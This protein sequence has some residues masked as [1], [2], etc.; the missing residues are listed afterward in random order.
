[1]A[2]IG[3]LLFNEVKET[4]CKEIENRLTQCGHRLVKSQSFIVSGF[5]SVAH[6]NVAV[7]TGWLR[8]EAYSPL[9]TSSAL[10]SRP[11]KAGNAAWKH[12]FANSPDVYARTESLARIAR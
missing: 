9:A 7:L 12:A 10:L 5:G 11:A 2:Q 1:M 8:T 4:G 6:V 3:D